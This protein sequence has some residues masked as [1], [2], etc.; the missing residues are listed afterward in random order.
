MLFLN[1]HVLAVWF[2]IN[3]FYIFILVV[4][5]MHRGE[6][7]SDNGPWHEVWLACPMMAHQVFKRGQGNEMMPFLSCI[8]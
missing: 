5:F 4:C 6:C 8:C 7:V 3:A 2:F 1:K